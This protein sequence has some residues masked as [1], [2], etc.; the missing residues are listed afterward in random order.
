MGEIFHGRAKQKEAGGKIEKECGTCVLC[1]YGSNIPAVLSIAHTK[2]S[3]RITDALRIQTL[4]FLLALR[5]CSHLFYV[6]RAR[7]AVTP[8]LALSSLGRSKKC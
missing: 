7:T 6:E 2:C 3:S 1:E 8:V 5:T 4:N